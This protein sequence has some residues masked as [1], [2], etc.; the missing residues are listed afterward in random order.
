M[1]RTALRSRSGST[2]ADVQ[3]VDRTGIVAA[4]LAVPRPEL[5]DDEP[6]AVDPAPVSAAPSPARRYGLVACAAFA[7]LV[8]G[9]VGGGMFGIPRGGEPTTPAVAYSGNA[10]EEVPIVPGVRVPAPPPAAQPPVAVPP[11]TRHQPA[12]PTKAVAETPAPRRVPETA[13]QVRSDPIEPR[14]QEAA[15]P[16][17]AVHEEMAKAVAPMADVLRPMLDAMPGKPRE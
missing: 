16:L 10:Y 14:P 4:S 7:F 1:A 2:V 12:K 5:P 9:W 13:P 11:V 15:G 6:F 8:I 17:A 3:L